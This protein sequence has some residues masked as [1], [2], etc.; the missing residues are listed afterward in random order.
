VPDAT[1]QQLLARHELAVTRHRAAISRRLGL[2]DSEMLAVAHLAQRG[3]L[4]PGELG[5]LLDLSSGGVSALVA[6]LEDAGHVQREPHPTDGRSTVVSLSPALVERAGRA[7]GP[8][9]T[10]LDRIAGALGDADRR[11][12]HGYLARVVETS[13]RHADQAFREQRENGTRAAAT[14]V[15]SLWA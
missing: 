4:T 15:P 13:E 5:A 2:G 10:E 14:P 7:F 9:V 6:R 1:L 3:R 8:L 11:A 12:V